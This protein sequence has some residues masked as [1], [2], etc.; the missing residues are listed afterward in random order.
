MFEIFLN[1]EGSP[2]PALW[3]PLG[4]AGRFYIITK[5][6]LKVQG[7]IGLSTKSKIMP[8]FLKFNLF[9]PNPSFQNWSPKLKSVSNYPIW[10]YFIFYDLWHLISDKL[11][12]NCVGY[13]Q[14]VLK[15]FFEKF[16]ISANFETLW[17]TVLEKLIISLKFSIEVFI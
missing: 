8:T 10:R 7:I 5:W 15:P 1:S 12:I 3:R 13:V 11:P 4:R 6:W 14:K 9:W 2:N 16:E 17:S